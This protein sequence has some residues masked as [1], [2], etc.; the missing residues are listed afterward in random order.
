MV[1]NIVIGR[2]KEEKEKLGTNASVFIGKQYVKMGQISSLANPIYLDV[3]RSHVV[4]VCGKRGGGKSYTLGAIAEG[5]ANLPKDIKDNLS[6]V[7]LDTMGIFWTM[8]YENKADKEL[9]DNWELKAK[10]LDV[11]IFTP[12]GYYDEYKEKGIPTDYAF[13]IK[14]SELDADNWCASFGIDRDSEAGVLIARIVNNLRKNKKNYS[15]SDMIKSAGD[16]EKAE[17]NIKN[18]VGARFIEAENWGLFSVK[19]TKL[20]DVVKPGQVS[21]LDVSCYAT[22]PGSWGVRALVIALIAEKL[23]IERMIARK[24]EEF[25]EI[26]GAEIFGEKAT[27]KEMPLVWLVVDEAHELLPKEGSTVATRPLITILR[28]GRQPGIS[29]LLASQQ[30]GKIHTDVMTQADVVISHRLTAKL[31]VDALGLLMQSY[32]RQG[33]DKELNMLPSVKGAAIIFDDVNERIYP[34][35]VRPRFTWHGGGAPIA[36]R[37]KKELF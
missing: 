10:G 13:A 7:M 6:V 14:P 17:P 37:P 8:K 30:P 26:R 27:K 4:F 22:I 1:Y 32:M 3:N 18:V 16:D 15:I 2:T 35:Q 31:D 11:K 5:M 23:F 34:M 29:L 33:L 21:I 25:R 28:E 12:V 9:L 19:G 20:A 36:Y 24:T